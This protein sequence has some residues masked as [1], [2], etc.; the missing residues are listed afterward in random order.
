VAASLYCLVCLVVVEVSFLVYLCVYAVSVCQCVHVC[1]C[2]HM[3]VGACEC[4][5]NCLYNVG[6][7]VGVGGCGCGCGCVCVWVCMRV[8]A[9]GATTR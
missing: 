1:V 2:V 8:G 9:D 7:G 3:C 6:V 4:L 5:Y